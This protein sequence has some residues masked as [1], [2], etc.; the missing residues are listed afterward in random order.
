MNGIRKTAGGQEAGAHGSLGEG[1]GS[2]GAHSL[3]QANSAIAAEESEVS[4]IWKAGK[5]GS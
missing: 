5:G 3:P 2:S 4:L 1:L